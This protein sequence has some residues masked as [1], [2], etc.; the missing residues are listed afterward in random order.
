[1]T[2]EPARRVVDG[3]AEDA[4]L[5]ERR[6]EGDETE[7]AHATVGRLH[8]DDA[9]ERGRLAHRAAGLRAERD[10]DDARRDRGGRAARR[11]AGHARRVRSD[12]C[13][14]PYALFSVDEPIANSSMFVLPNDDR[15]GRAQAS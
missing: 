2:L 3:A 12:F 1:M 5:I 14:G 7:A 6:R 10:A 13:V 15:A 4:D 11:A 8:A 9:A